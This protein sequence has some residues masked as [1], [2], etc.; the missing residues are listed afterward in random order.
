MNLNFSNVGSTFAS[1]HWIPP[2][3]RNQNTSIQQYR[4]TVHN[5]EEDNTTNIDRVSGTA[6]Q[7]TSLH[8]NYHYTVTVVAVTNANGPNASIDLQTSEDGEYTMQH[9]YT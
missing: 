9:L 5:K 3:T 7:L 4:I 1:V 6:Y 8:P 2:Y